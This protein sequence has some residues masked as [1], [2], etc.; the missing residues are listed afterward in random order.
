MGHPGFEQTMMQVVTGHKGLSAWRLVVTG[1]EAHSSRIEE[2][3]SAIFVASQFV[4]YLKGVAQDLRARENDPAFEPPFTTISVGKIEGG[5]AMNI[6]PGRCAI[7][8][9][10][11]ALPTTDV[12]ALGARIHRF[13]DD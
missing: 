3:V 1:T 11:R 5:Q 10:F 6:V 12:L 2:S 8:W 7:D 9:E 4:E 13:V